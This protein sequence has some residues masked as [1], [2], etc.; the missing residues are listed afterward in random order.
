MFPLS[1]KIPELRKNFA[2]FMAYYFPMAELPKKGIGS[3][4]SLCEGG[5]REGSSIIFV[6]VLLPSGEGIFKLTG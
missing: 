4:V 5:A 2:F 3:T 6:I 1:K